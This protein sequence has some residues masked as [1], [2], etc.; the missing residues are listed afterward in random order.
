M[1]RHVPG[2]VVMRVEHFA[3]DFAS[4]SFGHSIASLSANRTGF[5]A[6]SRQRRGFAVFQTQK[7]TSGN[8]DSRAWK[9][10]IAASRRRDQSTI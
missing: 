9:P 10:V 5:G 4:E 6:H 7:S 3:A 2:Q 1:H 8:E